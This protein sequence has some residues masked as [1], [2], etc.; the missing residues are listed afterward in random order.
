M[1]TK[2]PAKPGV[3]RISGS[4]IAGKDSLWMGSLS[5]KYQVRSLCAHS[6]CGCGIH[7][8]FT[9]NTLSGSYPCRLTTQHFAITCSLHCEAPYSCYELIATENHN[10]SASPPRNVSLFWGQS[11]TC[12]IS[13]CCISVHP[14]YPVN[15]Y[16]SE[17]E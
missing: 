8:L 14:T 9:P 2:G 1:G 7:F 6:Y 5:L 16:N 12:S 4:F 11:R 17:N 3:V 13:I 15:I 10:P